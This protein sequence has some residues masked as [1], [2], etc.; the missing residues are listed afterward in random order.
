M[1]TRHNC[2]VHFLLRYSLLIF[3][4]CSSPL[5][6]WAGNG[7]DESGPKIEYPPYGEQKVVFEFY[8]N[9]PAKL[10][11]AL[12]WIRTE[13][14][15]L[16]EKPYDI[17]PDFI[18]IKVV[19]HGTEVVTLAKKNYAKYRDLVERMRYY[20]DLGVDFRICALSLKQF[21][22]KPKDMQD[23]ITIAPSAITELAYWQSKGYAL[24]TP[25]VSEKH[26]TVDE[27]R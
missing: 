13:L 1:N 4:A 8:F 19:M 17:A 21:G 3:L 26:F 22:Y 14:Y 7:T 27:L 20:A 5:V 16:G 12:Y 9:S 23:F 2:I 10:S 24:I 25:R 15:T 11:T 18:K 6:C